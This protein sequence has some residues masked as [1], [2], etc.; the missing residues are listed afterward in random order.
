MP[1]FSYEYVTQQSRLPD[2]AQ[3]V[4]QS[5]VLAEDLETTGFNPITSDPRIWSINTGK[6]VYVIDVRKT[7]RPDPIIKAHQDNKDAVIVG[8]NL[9]FDQK[10]LLYHY[11]LE[12]GK[13]FDCFRGSNLLW[14]GRGLGH[15]LYDLYRR[16][17]KKEPE[18]EDYGA[19]NWGAD[20][21]TKDQLDYAAEDVVFLPAIRDS[22]KP[23]LAAAN[24]NIIAAIEFQSILA[25]AAC[26]LNGFYLN[27]EK[28]RA[29]AAENLIKHD[30]MQE[31]LW[32]ELPDPSRMMMLP[33]FK[34]MWNL[35]STKQML[36]SLQLLGVTQKIKV[37]DQSGKEHEETV[38]LQETAEIT[39]AMAA[40]KY[41]EI[42]HLLSYREA[43][44]QLKMFGLEYLEFINPVTGRLHPD[45]F[46][47][48]VSGRFACSKPN[49]AQI[50]RDKRFRKCFEAAD[51]NVLVIAD[52]SNIEMRI[53]A[54]VAGDPVLIQVF[55]D[56]KDAHK[57]TAAI[58]TGKPEKEV[59][60]A[61]RQQAKPVNFGFV[62]GMQAPTLVLYAR[63][64][65]GVT[66][67]LP[68][69]RDFRDKYFKRFDGLRRWHER[70]Q[71]DGQ[72]QKKAWS[73]GGRLRYL[74]T[75]EFFNEYYNHPVQSTGAD[76]L[77]RSLR[78]VYERFKKLIGRPPTRI[79]GM[80]TPTVQLCHHVHDEIISE[81]KDD[82]DL[83]KQ[84]KHEQEEGMKEGMQPFLKRVPVSVEA[85]SGRTWAD[86]S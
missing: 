14:N 71:R 44:T 10:F 46:P 22:L 66:L 28:W 50:P 15:N 59:T 65:Y 82:E 4:S 69:A 56:D 31:V 76:G 55:V 54:E 7:G 18:V 57:Y 58:I 53:V 39:L 75:R 84:V 85:S 67:T 5:P 36:K 23:K 38:Q 48:L 33:G 25:E 81:V 42:D 79:K 32:K 61:E 78:C 80:P 29:V 77:K 63:A 49:L 43:T 52:Y 17:L 20:E 73:I 37:R 41:P 60:K 27:P 35:D 3:E 11:G 2:I 40:A 64:N 47:F 83:I 9:K 26:E 21:L 19:S 74:D 13:L 34:V 86:K 68:Q 62:Y 51:G 72:R 30:K 1:S 6:K 45:F 24:L 70:A 12:F 8:T 16:E